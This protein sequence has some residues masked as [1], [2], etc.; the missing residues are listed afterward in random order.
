MKV[1]PM[2]LLRMRAICSDGREESDESC[3][4]DWAV[5]DQMISLL[6]ALQLV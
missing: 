6:W 5:C 1:A 4:G 3:W 2:N